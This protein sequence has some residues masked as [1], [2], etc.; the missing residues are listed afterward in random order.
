GEQREALAYITKELGKLVKNP[1]VMAVSAEKHLE[2]D[3]TGS[4]MGDLLGHLTKFL[5]E[6]RGRILLDNAL[7]EGVEAARL[8]RK[9]IDARRRASQMTSEELSRRIGLLEKDLAGQSRTIEERRAGI[10]EEVSAI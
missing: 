7:G 9:G 5:A 6:E 3:I 2:G 8:L 1:V 10:R 4:G